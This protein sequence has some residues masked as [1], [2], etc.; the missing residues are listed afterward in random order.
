MSQR[1]L[2]FDPSRVLL[3]GFGGSLGTTEDE[4]VGWYH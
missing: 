3:V 4:M 2:P 1:L